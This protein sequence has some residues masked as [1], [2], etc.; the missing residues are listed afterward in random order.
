[1]KQHQ[2]PEK[3]DDLLE[4]LIFQW[5]V[6]KGI[7]DCVNNANKDTGWIIKV[8]IRVHTNIEMRVQGKAHTFTWMTEYGH[9]EGI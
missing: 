7:E 2:V 9:T 6:E 3:S 1:M 8:Q 5:L 4:D